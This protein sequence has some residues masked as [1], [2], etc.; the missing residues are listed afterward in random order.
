MEKH[1][2]SDSSLVTRRPCGL[3]I[4][5]LLQR[6]DSSIRDM[7]AARLQIKLI[8]TTR[9]CHLLDSAEA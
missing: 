4:A 2:L 6:P 8:T 1:S 3:P 7:H 9:A 5:C